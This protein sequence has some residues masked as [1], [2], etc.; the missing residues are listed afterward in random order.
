MKSSKSSS[1]S[2]NGDP[3]A[4]TIVAKG[5]D[6]LSQL[7]KDERSSNQRRAAANS[8]DNS[9]NEGSVAPANNMTDA[10]V[11][12]AAMA[13]GTSNDN[14]SSG[15]TTQQQHRSQHWNKA[16]TLLEKNP[17]LVSHHIL[18]LALKHK[19]PISVI[20]LLLKLNPAAAAI[21]NVG[22]TALQVAVQHG[23]AIDVVET[24]LKACPF[25]LVATNPGS[26]LDPLS[27]AKRFRAKETA[28]IRLLSLPIQHWMEGQGTGP[29]ASTSSFSYKQQEEQSPPPPPPPSQSA[30]PVQPVTT[31][32]SFLNP[33]PAPP[34][35][36]EEDRQELNNV[37]Q[38]CVGVVKGHKRLVRE[39]RQIKQG[40]V[41]TQKEVMKQHEDTD[42]MEASNEKRNKQIVSLMKQV[43]DE[44]QRQ[45]KVQLIALDMKE[46][47]MRAHVK[48]MERRILRKVREK[49]AQVGQ[50][51]PPIVQVKH[52]QQ[53]QN[54]TTKQDKQE[55]NNKTMK[56]LSLLRNQ[57]L[58][59]QRR[60]EL[61]EDDRHQQNS[62]GS[63]NTK[64][65]K[66]KKMTYYQLPYDKMVPPRVP[67]SVSPSNTEKTTPIV[68]CS[69]TMTDKETTDDDSLSLL[70]EDVHVDRSKN[71][72]GSSTAPWWQ[73]PFFW[74]TGRSCVSAP[75]HQT[76]DRAPMMVILKE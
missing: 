24:V 61:L 56:G 19:P 53:K 20:H 66:K 42:A 21:P 51:L 41:T 38:L 18:C 43:Q 8:G 31:P 37:K 45:F 35:L 11:L 28:L 44:Q 46:Q 4:R 70:S 1:S 73:P 33:Y 16:T 25:A 39:Y 7:S 3:V 36:C 13:R 64:S 50:Q 2:R 67:A 69:P 63:Q 75:D 22:P 48:R 72:R 23:C 29:T 26:Y 74:T 12:A 57:V 34:K 15:D 32:S 76:S 52:R 10:A 14:K 68:F 47:A 9:K 49:I 54:E 58:G 71:Q 60:L 55:G 30:M 65:R 62:Q 17:S 27:Y 5:E 59:M 40:V 6:P